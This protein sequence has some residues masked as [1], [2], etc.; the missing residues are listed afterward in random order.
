MTRIDHLYI[1]LP[2]ISQHWFTASFLTRDRLWAELYALRY[3]IRI[4]KKNHSSHSMI[5]SQ[6][7]NA[8]SHLSPSYR[9]DRPSGAFIGILRHA[10]S[11]HVVSNGP[12][13]RVRIT[14]ALRPP[15][16]CANVAPVTSYVSHRSRKRGLSSPAGM[17]RHAISARLRSVRR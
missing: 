1:T 3:E 7:Q 11:I 13:V 15:S 14:S 8:S 2:I 17:H 6:R 9:T 12:I 10:L 5:S 4:R 16:E